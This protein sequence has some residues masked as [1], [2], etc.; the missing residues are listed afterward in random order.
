MGTSKYQTGKDDSIL[1][2][3]GYEIFL[4]RTNF[5]N[6]MSDYF[7]QSFSESTIKENSTIRIL[8]IGSGNGDFTDLLISQIKNACTN[9]RI[10]LTLVEPAQEAIQQAYDKLSKEV[11]EIFIINS[12]V[13]DFIGSDHSYNQQYDLI[14]CNYIFYHVSPDFIKDLSDLLSQGGSLFIAMGTADHPLRKHPLLKKTSKHGDSSIL[15][16]PIKNLGLSYQ[17]TRK[18]IETNLDIRNLKTDHDSLTQ[19]GLAFFSFSYN[20]NL[21]DVSEEIK[22]AILATINTALTDQNGIIHPIHEA[23][24]IKRV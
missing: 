24:W 8:D 5:R 4:K 22:K 15:D 9:I 7:K 16:T 3:Q 20:Q 1:Y 14:L 19:E 17:V 10:N 12:T 23:I 13:E 21:Q 6:A 18:L 11:Q 2:S